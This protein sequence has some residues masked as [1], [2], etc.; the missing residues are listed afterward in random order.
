MSRRIDIELTSDRDD[1]TWT[2]R[3][4]GAREPKGVL[5]ASVLYDGAAVGDVCKAEAEFLIDGIE[6]T[7]TFAPKKK[8]DRGQDLLEM[9][10]RP[11]PDSELVT[12]VRAPKGRGGRRGDRG[13]RRGRRDERG[14]RG[15]RGNRGDRGPRRE[16]S[17]RSE[18]PQRPKAKRLRPKRV[19]RDAVLAE[20]PEEH[21]PIADQLLQ[22]GLPAVRQAIEK[23]NAEAKA[24]E[25]PE[26]PVDTVMSIAEPLAPR[27]RTAEWHD[28]ADA[29]L[30]DLDELDLRDLRSVVGAA[31]ANAR[32][33]ELRTL[34]DQ[35]REGLNTRVEADHAA[36]SSDLEAAVKEGRT[37]RAL[38][39][40]SRPVKAGS[41]LPP[42]LAQ[43]LAA[44]TSA[45]L[46]GDIA[47]DRW[48]TVVDAMAYSPIRN[49]VAPAG[50]PAEPSE[51]LL[52]AVRRVADRVPA[53]AAHFNID[54]SEA[55]K[56][57]R[58]RP[59]RNAKGAAKG[60]AK[61]ERG[62]RGERSGGRNERSGGRNE[63]AGGRGRGRD[64]DVPKQKRQRDLPPVPGAEPKPDPE[65]EAAAAAAEAEATEAATTETTE[66]TTDAPE[67]T[68]APDAAEA[69]ESADAPEPG[70]D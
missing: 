58:R 43:Q 34:A 45:A 39:L 22:G 31:D 35:L 29:A 41:P 52:E 9:V 65:A 53:I 57:K 37:V 60:G 15:D 14:D 30:A 54:P 48:A 26:V 2:W 62:E 3:A 20:V 7:Q 33:D 12:E 64:A 13:E 36:W 46:A 16:R 55:A 23:Q 11:V 18:A 51:E 5:E 6:V 4:A 8:K 19:H 59:K 21:R 70:D 25:K 69:T 50:Y 42:E 47:Q 68:D 61:G 38:R 63:R 49:A 40:S 32:S 67:S 10:S 17:E 24:A 44:A 1:G 27:L 28:K 66:A 56:A